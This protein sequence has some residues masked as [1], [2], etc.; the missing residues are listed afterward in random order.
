MEKA[1]KAIDKSA[2]DVED[3]VKDAAEKAEEALEDEKGG[4]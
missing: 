2:H 1:G 3:A 4:H